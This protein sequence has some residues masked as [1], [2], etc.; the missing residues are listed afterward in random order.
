[1]ESDFK[2]N[3]LLG[4]LA[5]LTLLG[6]RADYT[7]YYADREDEGLAI[8]SNTNN[9][10][11]S[12]FIAGQPWRTASRTTAGFSV[13]TNYEIEIERQA[14]FTAKD[15]LVIQW[16]GFYQ[17]NKNSEGYISLHLALPSG[18]NFKDLSDMQGKRMIVDS[19]S[20]Y[21]ETAVYNSPPIKGNGSIYF[22]TAR[23]DSVAVDT[24]TGN[25]SGLFEADFNSFKI[26]RGRLD[27]FI[28][29]EQIRL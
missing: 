28:T 12:C 1:M 13:R 25:M 11:M 15:T 4:C 22:H 29:P 17:A 10:L 16:R 5:V 7:E 9:N 21:F 26:T 18:F 24:Y 19:S 2:K 8:F 6:C 20:G 27:H 3:L 23:F 14:T